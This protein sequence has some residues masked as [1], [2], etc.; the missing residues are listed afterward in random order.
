MTFNSNELV[1]IGTLVPNFYNPN[2]HKFIEEDGTEHSLYT[3]D[4]ESE[5]PDEVF[6]LIKFKQGRLTLQEA[7]TCLLSL[8][9][10]VFNQRFVHYEN[11]GDISVAI[12]SDNLL[13]FRNRVADHLSSTFECRGD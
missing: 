1:I 3:S 4:T 6:I 5:C 2:E 11:V 7:Y 13:E 8:K 12:C 9:Q 10:K